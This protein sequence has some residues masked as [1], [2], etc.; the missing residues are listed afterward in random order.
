V[1]VTSAA[2]RKLAHPWS[3]ALRSTLPARL[4][5]KSW[6]QEDWTIEKTPVAAASGIA[7]AG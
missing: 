3:M 4:T 7:I 2:A 1:I 5:E 6:I